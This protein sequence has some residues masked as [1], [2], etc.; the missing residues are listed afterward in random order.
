[1]KV[2]IVEDHPETAQ[3]LISIV[4]NT[5]ILEFHKWYKTG[6]EIM[7]AIATDP[8]EVY[9]VDI[10][11]PNISG[12]DLILR[13]RQHRAGAK[14]IMH[15]VFEEEDLLLAAIENGAD[16]YL[17]K[18]KDTSRIID[19]IK[20]VMQGGFS[21]TPAVAKKILQKYSKTL[22]P[23]APKGQEQVLTEREVEILSFV[24]LGLRQKDIADELDISYHTVRRHIESIYQKLKVSNKIQA[25]RAAER[26]NILQRETD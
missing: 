14:I 18:D 23:D 10:G 13:I 22:K 4:G 15:T 2:S 8:A 9:I 25:L 17:L 20:S 26:L 16:G 21:L 19:E 1:M 3:N 12:I 24:A 11:L 7:E 6:E 5:E